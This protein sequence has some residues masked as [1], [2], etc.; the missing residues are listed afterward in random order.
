ML[1]YHGYTLL[2]IIEHM[3]LTH[4]ELAKKSWKL[5]VGLSYITSPFV[6]SSMNRGGVMLLN[7]GIKN[8][9]KG[10]RGEYV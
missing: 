8:V 3:L 5:K 4:D 9:K 6:S 1:T 2:S 7:D 10:T